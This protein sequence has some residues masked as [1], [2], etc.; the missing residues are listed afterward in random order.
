M[1]GHRAETVRRGCSNVGKVGEKPVRAPEERGPP[2]FVPLDE[3][4]VAAHRQP[5]AVDPVR[6]MPPAATCHGL[7]EVLEPLQGG[8]MLTKCA[9]GG[10]VQRIEVGYFRWGSIPRL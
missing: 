6:Q 9:R 8:R 3:R 7:V 4:R 10:F 5:I 1:R 2:I